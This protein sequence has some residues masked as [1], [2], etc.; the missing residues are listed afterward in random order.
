MSF[1]SR[2]TVSG[3]PI[4]L[5]WLASAQTVGVTAAQS[6]PR[7]SFVDVFPVEPTTATTRASLFARTREASAASAAFWSSGTSVAR[8]ARPCFGDM[9]DTR[10][11]RD[12]QIAGAD[13]A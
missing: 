12:E 13:G 8:T 6:A 10:V 4:S 9:L 7:T 3:N 2:Q 11:E 1:S 5:F